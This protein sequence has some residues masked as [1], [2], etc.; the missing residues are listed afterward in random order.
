MGIMDVALGKK[1]SKGTSNTGG[2][3]IAVDYPQENERV[4]STSYTF[5]LSPAP[6]L[7]NIEV[8]INGGAW[9][10]CRASAGF[11]W[12]DWQGAAAGSYILLARG[13]TSKGDK[14]MSARRQ[15]VVKL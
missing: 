14:V 4:T 5:R 10:P 9:Q 11:W 15:F 3:R 2:T 1:K 8:S 13:E 12:Y 6:E 7:K